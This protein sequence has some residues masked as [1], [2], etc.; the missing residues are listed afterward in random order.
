MPPSHPA[1]SLERDDPRARVLERLAALGEMAT[2]RG[3]ASTAAVPGAR[4]LAYACGARERIDRVEVH[5]SWLIFVLEGHKRIDRKASHVLRAGDAYLLPQGVPMGVTNV[6]DGASRRYR[7]LGV[8]IPG[9]AHALVRR[10]HPNLVRDAGAWLTDAHRMGRTLRASLAALQALAHVCETFLDP[11]AHPRLLHHRIE[12]LL[13]ALLMDEATPRASVAR[14]QAATNV[15]HAVRNLVRGAPD[16]AWPAAGVA[17]SLGVSA[18]TLRRRL[19]AEGTTLRALVLEERL[20]LA[21]VLLCDGRLGV[22]EIALRCGYTSPGKFTRQFVRRF[23]MS[24][25]RARGTSSHR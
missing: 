12:G 20:E 10:H 18:A 19:A 4:L 23:G 24:P 9:D 1:P 5:S 8:E 17:R 16:V 6:P 14:A 2:L 11:A 25:S 13:L 22:T 21:R 7:S 15:A 3:A